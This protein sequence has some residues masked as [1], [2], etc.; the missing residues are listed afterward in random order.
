VHN[1]KFSNLLYCSTLNASTAS[2]VLARCHA[3]FLLICAPDLMGHVF[4]AGQLVHRSIHAPGQFF[5]LVPEPPPHQ[6]LR[7]PGL[8]TLPTDPR[9]ILMLSSSS[10][11]LGP[12]PPQPALLH[13]S[14]PA[15]A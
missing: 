3:S 14:S 13:A 5:L 8:P 10:A 12:A 4:V 2:E 9:F 11:P 7:K 15:S 6:R 1:S